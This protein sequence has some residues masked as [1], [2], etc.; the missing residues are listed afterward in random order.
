M[1]SAVTASRAERLEPSDSKIRFR[2]DML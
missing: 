2:E 1:P